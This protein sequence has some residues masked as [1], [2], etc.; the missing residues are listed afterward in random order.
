M[1][2]NKIVK[3]VSF[4]VMNEQDQ[5]YL[6]RIQDV[7]FS[8]YI[9]RLIDKDIRQ[10]KVIKAENKPSQPAISDGPIIIRSTGLSI[11]S[12]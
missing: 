6:D 10:R 8:G 2:T 9:K 11:K 5:A 7:N 1:S 3:S 12:V 4:N